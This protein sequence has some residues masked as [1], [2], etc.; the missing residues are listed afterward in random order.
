ME[1]KARGIVY[2]ALIA[3]LT[4]AS[5]PD[6]AEAARTGADP[7][8]K[9]V[10]EGADVKLATVDGLLA[11]AAARRARADYDGARET[12]VEALQ[13]L[14]EVLPAN[15]VRIAQALVEY[16]ASENDSRRYREAEALLREALAMFALMDDPPAGFMAMAHNGIA[17]GH[18]HSG[19][20]DEAIAAYREAKPWYEES[21][22]VESERYAVWL[23]N[24]SESHRQKGEVAEAE[25]LIAQAY[26]I[27]KRVPLGKQT[28]GMITNN[29]ATL[30]FSQGRP[31]EAQVLFEEALVL[32]ESALG[33][34]HPQTASSY[35]NIGVSLYAQKR[36]R[37]AIV[38]LERALA[39]MEKLYGREH[40]EVAYVL[41]NLVD[42]YLAA[43]EVKR[44][45]DAQ[46]R[47]D[48][49]K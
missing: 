9:P 10:A 27:A 22:G 25:P 14:R 32:S 16:G 34:E 29:L 47:I 4:L 13:I 11:D 7:T 18:H 3:A 19:R 33:S 2:V 28:K 15:D 8:A 38:P 44:S 24:L 40:P 23:S 26:E 21:A 49:M 42:V 6:P 1:T 46:A 17:Y 31:A 35:A 20:Y 12:Y 30:R 39:I 41:S 43:G 37:E 45:L 5:P 48:G 36:H